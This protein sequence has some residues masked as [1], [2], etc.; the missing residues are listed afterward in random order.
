LG[1]VVDGFGE[2][3]SAAKTGQMSFTALAGPVGIAVMAVMELINAFREYGNEVD[4]TNIKIEAYAASATELT[5]IIEQ[6][7]TKR[8]SKHLGFNL[9]ERK[10]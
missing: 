7:S 4:G 3:A 1:G 6:N 8:Q 9:K 10:D 5:S 2:L